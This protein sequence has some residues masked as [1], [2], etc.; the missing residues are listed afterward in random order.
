MVKNHSQQRF[1]RAHDFVGCR[2]GLAPANSLQAFSDRERI[3]NL[4]EQQEPYLQ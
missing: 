1:V 2:V 4:T 3:P